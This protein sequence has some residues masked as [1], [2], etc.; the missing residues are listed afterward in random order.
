MAI[1]INTPLGTRF[2]LWTVTGPLTRDSG[3]TVCKCKCECGTVRDVLIS[4]LRNG[5]STN[6]GCV[7]R[8][9]VAERNR[10]HGFSNTRLYYVWCSIKSR[11]ASKKEVN[12]G[13]RG[14][15][16]C[17]EWQRFEPFRKWAKEHGYK[18]GA[19]IDRINVNGDYEPDNCRF[20]DSS[21]NAANQ[22][23]RGSRSGFVGVGKHAKRWRA[24]LHWRH[25]LI[26]LGCHDTPR[27]AAMVR[28][29]YL[30]EHDLPHARNFPNEVVA[31]KVA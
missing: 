22:R 30:I 7:R 18:Q 25:E 26:N 10:T 31:Y 23:P 1:R 21:T 11:C 2:G 24:T 3:D 9:R 28:E 16:V 20:V 15:K 5:K 13:A 12:Y 27:I 4:S 29:L 19:I 6:C 17:S 14:I 8:R